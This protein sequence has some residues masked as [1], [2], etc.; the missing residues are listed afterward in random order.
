MSC[1][2]VSC[3]KGSCRRSWELYREA[4][5]AIAD[6][7][8]VVCCDYLPS[9]RCNGLMIVQDDCWRAPRHASC[10]IC[11]NYVAARPRIVMPEIPLPDNAQM[12][13]ANAKHRQKWTREEAADIVYVAEFDVAV[14]QEREGKHEDDVPAETVDIPDRVHRVERRIVPDVDRVAHE[15]DHLNGPIG[16][17]ESY[18]V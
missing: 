2:C 15:A 10:M 3:R 5:F 7:R 12:C 6:G 18:D 8:E 1:P 16:E 11:G 17:E 14:R 4:F 13:R 9:Y